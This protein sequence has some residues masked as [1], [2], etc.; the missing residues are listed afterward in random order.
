MGGLDQSDLVSG[1]FVAIFPNVLLS[2][3]PNH[4]F[5]MRLD[6]VAPGVT[7]ET[8]TFLL[9]EASMDV[10]EAAFAPTRKFWFE[11]NG[12][13]IDIVQRSQRGLTHGAPPAGPLIGRF[14]EP[15]RRFHNILADCMTLDSLSSIAV[16]PGDDLSDPASRLGTAA[17]PTPPTIDIR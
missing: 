2:V 8:C 7:A 4:I 13:D 15:L 6:P 16:Q 14:E 5:V 11:V 1:R 12:E 10:D 9:P 3:L 17:N